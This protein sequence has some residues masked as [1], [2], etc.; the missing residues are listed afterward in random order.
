MEAAQGKPVAGRD[1]P[2]SYAQL[3]AWFSEDA[4]CLDYLD[5]LRWPKGFICPHCASTVGWRLADGRW[6]CGG[7]DR[8]VSATAGTIFDKTRTPLS[9]WFAAAWLM[10]NSKTGISATQLQREMELGSI[11]TAWA[12]LHRYRSVMVRAGRNRLHGD[13]EVDKSY[14]GGPEPGVPGRGALG[15]VLFAAAVEIDDHRLGRAR[16]GLIPDASAESLAAFLD[17]NV[18][19]GSRIITDGWSSYRPATRGRYEHHGTS[20]AASGLPA[21]VVLPATHRVFSLVKRWVMGTLQGSVAPE[22]LQAYFDEWVFG[23]NRRHSRS[24]GLLLPAALSA[25]APATLRAHGPAALLDDGSSLSRSE[26]RA[27]GA[28]RRPVVDRGVSIERSRGSRRRR[29]GMV[30]AGGGPHRACQGARDR[31]IRR[32]M[33]GNGKLTRVAISSPPT[34]TLARRQGGGTLA[35]GRRI[36]ACQ[37]S[38]IASIAPPPGR[39]ALRVRSGFRPPHSIAKAQRTP[40]CSLDRARNR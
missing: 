13:V 31:P 8:K 1:Y 16:V 14:L 37:T 27:E 33:I 20:I 32:V 21:H 30:S 35:E 6:K 40:E 18:E 23:F 24:Q 11:Q 28:L 4:K 29:T 9:I 10:V 36:A 15:K 26:C 39:E 7:C 19:P 22:H 3:R 25:H 12:M 17:A 5:W 2:R 34:M 38:A